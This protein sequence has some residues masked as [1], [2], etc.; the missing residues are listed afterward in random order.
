MTTRAVVTLGASVVGALA[1]YRLSF[2]TFVLV[3]PSICSKRHLSEIFFVFFQEKKKKSG[4]LV[5][6]CGLNSSEAAVLASKAGADLLGLIFVKKSKR[7]VDVDKAKEIVSAVDSY[8]NK[9][10]L[11]TPDIGKVIKEREEVKDP[12]KWFKSQANRISSSIRTLGDKAA[13]LK[14]GV[15]MNHSVNDIN[16]IV[17]QLHLDLIQLHGNEP[18]DM[19]LKLSRPSIRVIHVDKSSTLETLISQIKPGLSPIVM[20]D[21]KGGGTG[22]AFDWTLATKISK[23]IPIFLAGGLTP[24]NAK[25]AVDMVS[26]LGIDACGGLEKDG[27]KGVK[28][29]RKIA[30]FVKSVRAL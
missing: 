28:D 16:H 11:I 21:S 9:N 25:D 4:V 18:E 15:F 7:Y 13:P 23:S 20:L 5:K 24:L 8:I 17:H 6:V 26:P 30:A 22:K 14:V 19:P 29:L 10:G 3:L 27:Q 2:D 1:F 12:S